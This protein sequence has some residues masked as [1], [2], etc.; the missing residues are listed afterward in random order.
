MKKITTVILILILLAFT[1]CF[2]EKVKKDTA[3]PVITLKGEADVSFFV[4]DI[5]V[6]WSNSK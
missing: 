1:G 4:N 6:G 5:Y 2:E 3:K